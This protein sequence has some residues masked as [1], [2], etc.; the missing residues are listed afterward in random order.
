MKQKI[1]GASTVQRSIRGL[2]RISKRVS[3]ASVKKKKKKRE[4]HQNADE[5]AAVKRR[6][7]QRAVLKHRPEGLCQAQWH[8]LPVMAGKDFTV[9]TVLRCVP[10]P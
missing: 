6:L 8:P 1:Q 4:R 7:F 2:C 3:K 10:N 9:E 5:Y